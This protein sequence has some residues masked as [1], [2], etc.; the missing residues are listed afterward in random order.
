MTNARLTGALFL[1]PALALAQGGPPGP[2]QVTVESMVIT[3]ARIESTVEAVGTV[4]ADA[5]ATVRAEVPGQIIERHFEDGDPV[6]KGAPLFSIEATVLEA[7]ANEARATVVQSE[8]AYKR[9]QELVKNNLISATDYDTA[10]ANY[11][12]AVARLESSEAR[13]YKTVIRAPFDGFAGLRRVNVG[14]YATIGQ[15]MV[16]VVRLDP[17]R[18]DFSVPET[19][20]AR[21]HPG[22]AINVTVGAFPGQV[23]KGEVTAI[24]PQIDVVGHSLEVRASLPNSDLKLRPGLFAKVSVTLAFRP[25]ALLVPEE[26]IWPI[27]NDKTVYVIEE[28][29][30]KR[31][32]VQIGERKPGY[33]EIVAGLTAGEEIVIAGQMKLFEG[34]AVKTIP[35]IV[36]PY[37][38]S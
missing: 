24:D 25:D 36:G 10:R 7:E 3:P 23:F 21:V 18:V 9:A 31:R 14:D 34:A 6:K 37:Q 33:V 4:L 30:A 27:G 26:A 11:N 1:L 2:R 22:L 17:L 20:L 29:V 32:T 19:M 13:L 28:G 12:V 35:S 16:N 5:S 38:G 8:A 15:E